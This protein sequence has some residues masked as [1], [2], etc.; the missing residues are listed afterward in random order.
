MLKIFVRLVVVL[1]VIGVVAGAVYGFVNTSFGSSLVNRNGGFEHRDFG[2]SN[3]QAFTPSQ[4]G[5]PG[6][7]RGH[8]FEGGV[9]FTQGL[10]GIVGN[11]G[12]IALIVAGWILASSG[13]HW[14][15]QMLRRRTTFPASPAA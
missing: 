15:V 6:G 11:I 10:A 7:E 2:G 13:F 1:A 4:A 12:K 5:F 14:M 3:G 9:G 8:D